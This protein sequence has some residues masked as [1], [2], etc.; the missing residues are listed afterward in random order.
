MRQ[1]M[2]QRHGTGIEPKIGQKLMFQDQSNVISGTLI[3]GTN[4]G[5]DIVRNVNGNLDGLS[6]ACWHIHCFDFM[7]RIC[8]NGRRQQ[9]DCTM[10]R[11][12]F[13]LSGPVEFAC[14]SFNWHMAH[15]SNLNVFF[16]ND[17]S[18]IEGHNG[19]KLNLHS[20]NG[21]LPS[22]GN[23]SQ[24]AFLFDHCGF[25]LQRF[26]GRMWFQEF[27]ILAWLAFLASMLGQATKW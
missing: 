15:K 17:H 27:Q 23:L 19:H 14:S 5:R 2:L 24:N 22:K 18:I 4:T 25:K 21:L 7:Q 8:D 11:N 12:L 3:V 26:S 1:Q 9:I 16:G 6:T 10:P 13:V 20:G